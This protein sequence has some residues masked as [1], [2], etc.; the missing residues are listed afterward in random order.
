MFV[1]ELMCL[2]PI[3]L[4]PLYARLRGN[5]QASSAVVYSPVP[6]QEEDDFSDNEDALTTQHISTVKPSIQEGQLPMTGVHQALFLFP[7]VCDIAGT[8]LMNVGLILTPVSIYQMSRGALVL[9]VG[10]LSVIFL[11]RKL[12]A[13]QWASL[14]IVMLGVALVGLAGSMVKKTA[15]GIPDVDNEAGLV[16][17]LLKRMA[18]ATAEMVAPEDPTK[19]FVGV[20]L[21]TGAQIFTATQF[22]AVGLEGF[23]GLSVILLFMPALHYFFAAKSPY[24]DIPRGFHQIVDHPLVLSLSVAIC[25]SIA[26]FNLCGLGVTK[27]VSASASYGTFVFNGLV[28]PLI[29]APDP[30][31]LVALPHEAVLDATAVAPAA[32][33]QGR[34]GYD[35]V[36]IDEER[37]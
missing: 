27:A 33:R 13:Y 9:W 6:Q 14:I 5:Q 21:I 37:Q 30:E 29:F 8:T 10:V 36:P 35:V 15:V 1:G 32:Q 18:V 2:V 11:G 25:F 3:L 26:A 17:A 22:H 24:F 20:L 23:W 7:A 12:R 19:V 34:I 28:R 31:E 16:V 4:R